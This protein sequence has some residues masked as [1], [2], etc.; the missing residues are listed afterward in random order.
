MTWVM[1]IAAG[2]IV[3]VV[4]RLTQSLVWCAVAGMVAYFVLVMML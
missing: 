4:A 1:T 2:G 3:V